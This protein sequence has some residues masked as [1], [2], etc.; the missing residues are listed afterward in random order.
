MM[1]FAKRGLAFLLTAMTMLTALPMGAFAATASSSTNTTPVYEGDSFYS[2]ER[3]SKYERYTTTW[4]ATDY[5]E[6]SATY[7]T[8]GW[9]NEDYVG[10]AAKLTVYYD[11]ASAAQ[12]KMDLIVY[13]INYEGERM[14]VGENADDDI[15]IIT[16]YINAPASE[17]SGN[18][19]AVMVVDFGNTAEA[20]TAKVELS[21]T[22]LRIWLKKALTINSKVGS[23]IF[24]NWIYNLPAGYRVARDIPFFDSSV[25]ASLGTRQYVLE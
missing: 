5:A 20:T 8:A 11:E 25:H 19:T 12:G 9:N 1:K 22:T 2:D 17:E 16:D 24:S 15:A 6:K 14:A 7:S 3:L 10:T 18:R 4:T 23:N 21:L 13:V